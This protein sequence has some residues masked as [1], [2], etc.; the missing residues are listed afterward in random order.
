MT[1]STKSARANSVLVRERAI[2]EPIQIHFA[3]LTETAKKTNRVAENSFDLRALFSGIVNAS[4]KR[5]RV[6]Q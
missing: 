6:A 5:V 1:I 3:L 4:K 2:A